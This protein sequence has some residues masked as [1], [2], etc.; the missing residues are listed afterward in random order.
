M[1]NGKWKMENESSPKNVLYVKSMA[2]SLRI[3]K[4][5]EYLKKETKCNRSIINQ[6]VRSGTSI[7][8]N[9]AESINAESKVDFA[10]KLSIALKEADETE[11]WLC[12]IR[13]GYKVNVMAFN[14]LISDLKEIKYILIASIKTA[15][16][17]NKK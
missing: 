11:G 3:I 17:I 13:D 4:M 8:A 1:E 6:V 5:E 15:K 2:F 16:G 7:S 9:I 10:H 14:S 12:N